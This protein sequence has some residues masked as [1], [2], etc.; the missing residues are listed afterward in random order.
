L[1]QDRIVIGRANDC[2][3]QIPDSAVSS[4]HC[5]LHFDGLYWWITDLKSRNGI[6]VNGK[7]TNRRQLVDHDVIIISNTFRFRMHDAHDDSP[8]DQK[9]PAKSRT[10]LVLVAVA[11]GLVAAA[12]LYIALR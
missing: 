6:G 2:D 11:I 4:R 8:T 10:G 7:P 3:L 5:E 9:L 1:I 12:S